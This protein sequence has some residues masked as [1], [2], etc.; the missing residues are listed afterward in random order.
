MEVD[1]WWIEDG[2]GKSKDGQS[3]EEE[4]LKDAEEV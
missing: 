3:G 2:D 4:A 1:R